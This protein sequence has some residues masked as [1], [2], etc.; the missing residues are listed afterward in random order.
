MRMNTLRDTE[1]EREELRLRLEEI[2]R[3]KEAIR[4][5]LCATL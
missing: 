5:I 2:E 3:D 1:K 4:S